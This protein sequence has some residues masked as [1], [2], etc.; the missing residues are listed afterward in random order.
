MLTKELLVA[1]ESL[2]GLTEE[3]IQA[4]TT[5][6]SNDE[7]AVIGA[8]IGEIYRQMDSTIA[9]ATGVQRNGDEKTYLYLKR[10]ASELSDKAKQADGLT[11]TIEGLTKEKNRLEKVIAEGA[12]DSETKKALTQAQKDLTSIT[13]QYNELKT[14]YD[15]EKANHQQ[16]LLNLRIDG[17]LQAATKGI[18][19]KKDLPDSVKTVI[20][21]QAVVK[22][23]GMHPE[24]IDNGQG[25]QVLAFKDESGAILR[26][27]EN[28]LNPFTASEL[29]TKELSDMGVLES[30]RRATGGGTEPPAGGGKKASVAIDVTGV[31][32]QTKAYEVIADALI[33]KGINVGT[34]EF[35]DAMTQAW[36]DNNIKSLPTQ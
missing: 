7:N 12:A 4:I 35:D 16:E 19:L 30:P 11:K 22:I 28:K 34:K 17:E 15:N 25:G 36:K 18:A 10:A 2:A 14:Q 8:R 24:Y 29:L 3:Q 1:N 5:L 6:S 23:K 13:K 9:E 33:A 20:M 31:T 27:Q 32:T 21:N 26:N